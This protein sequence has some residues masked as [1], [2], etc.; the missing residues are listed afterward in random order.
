MTKEQEQKIISQAVS[1]KELLEIR[2]LIKH[3][4]VCKDDEVVPDYE[5]W[6]SSDEGTSFQTIKEVEGIDYV[7]EINTEGDIH[8]LEEK[9]EL[10]DHG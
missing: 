7:L 8:V 2:K 4:K 1:D 5:D 6:H 3:N 10:Q 9:H